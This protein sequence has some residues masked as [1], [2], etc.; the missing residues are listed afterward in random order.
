MSKPGPLL[1]IDKAYRWLRLVFGYTLTLTLLIFGIDYA[2][3]ITAAVAAGL[4]G[5]DELRQR[6]KLHWSFLDPAGFSVADYALA[7]V[8]AL[9]ALFAWSI[10]G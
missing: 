7:V 8:G 5:L 2:V 6:K 9:L 3:L 4:E 1:I 10:T